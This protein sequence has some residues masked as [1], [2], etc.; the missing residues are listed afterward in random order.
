MKKALLALEDG[1]VF[2]GFSF[3]AEGETGGEVVFNTA[4][5]GYQE[6]ITDPSYKGQI[7][8]MTYPLI[9]NYGVNPEDVESSKPW[10]EGF[11]VKELSRIVSNWRATESLD[12]YLRRHNVIGIQG[13]DT[14]ELTKRLRDVGSQMGVISTVDLDPESLVK[15]ARALPGIEGR[16]LVQDVTC[17]AP[18]EWNEGE[19][20]LEG[21][22]KKGHVKP[23]YHVVVYDFG[24]KYNILRL[25]VEEGFKVTVVPASTSADDVL[26]LDPDGVFLSNGPGDP[27]PV[28]YAI[29]NVK[30]LLGRVPICGICLGHQIIGLALG[31][32]TYKLKFGHHGANHPVK[33]L[34]T[35][36]IEITSQNHNFAVDADSLGQD[37]EVTHLNLNDHTVEGLRHRSLPVFSV[38]F[39]PEASP[40]PHD[41]R[42]IF[43]RFAQLI[44]EFSGSI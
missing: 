16:D 38:Q 7:V 25:L 22:Y 33:D 17:R 37:V 44:E 27:A 18:Y 41:S 15:K 5:T 11:V 1:T 40:G 31:G 36:R 12:S 2:E 14:R 21:G 24:V 26:G 10:I 42:G 23:G 6:I 43:S 34:T 20:T 32:R 3:G 28:S 9:G 4:M 29:D 8:T 35:G 39:H 30:R 19:W 13:I